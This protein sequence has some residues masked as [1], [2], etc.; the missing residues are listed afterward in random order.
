MRINTAPNKFKF[1]PKTPLTYQIMSCL[2]M[3]I[4]VKKN[5]G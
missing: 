1:S 4:L 5:K 2:F 3:N